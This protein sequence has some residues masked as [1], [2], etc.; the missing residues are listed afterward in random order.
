MTT[1]SIL[2]PAEGGW[3][4]ADLRKALRKHG[5]TNIEDA[6]TPYVGHRAIDIPAT[7]VTREVEDL[8]FSK[9]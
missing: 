2:K 6:W 9:G 3:K 7:Q 1:F 8:I 5:I 4:M